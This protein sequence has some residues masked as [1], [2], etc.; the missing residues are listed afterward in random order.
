MTP[1][2]RVEAMDDG[3]T[4]PVW[5]KRAIVG[6]WVGGLVTYYVVGVMQSLGTLITVL[7]VSLFVAFALEPAVNAMA[8]RGSP[9]RHRHRHHVRAS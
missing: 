4:V 3:R 1:V 9:P 5:V 6:F 2:A 7:L 8:R